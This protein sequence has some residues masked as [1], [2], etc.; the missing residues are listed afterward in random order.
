M[1][2]LSMLC[3]LCKMC[4]WSGGVIILLVTGPSVC[5]KSM[6]DMSG[7]N[8]TGLSTSVGRSL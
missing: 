2:S 8:V 5:G 6:G 3:G 7:R 1:V 4:S